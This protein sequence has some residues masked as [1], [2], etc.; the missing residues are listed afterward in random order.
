M[1]PCAIV[2]VVQSTLV[3]VGWCASLSYLPS[4]RAFALIR[5]EPVSSIGMYAHN[6]CT[7]NT[8]WS[9]P[10]RYRRGVSDIARIYRVRASHAPMND[11]YT[12]SHG[13]SDA[14]I[15][16]LV[17]FIV[18][19]LCLTTATELQDSATVLQVV[20][21]L[22]DLYITLAHIII[23]HGFRSILVYK[24]SGVGSMLSRIITYTA[25]R[26]IVLMYAP[27]PHSTAGDS[28]YLHVLGWCKL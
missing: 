1:R 6:S 4:A 3:F 9:A 14:L 22:A 28:H 11:R 12:A 23:L 24:T 8:E 21:V 5:L 19:I 16:R 2:I 7:C 13:P 27:V 26:G 20:N 18:E 25:S 15:R 10:R 17:S